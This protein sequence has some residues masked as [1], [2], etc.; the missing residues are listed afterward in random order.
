V[1]EF[2]HRPHRA[3]T[4]SSLAPLAGIRVVDFSRLFAGPICTMVL[5]DLGAE[6][7]KVEPP[8]GDEA[9]LFGPPFL[10]GEGMNYIALNRGK[11][12]VVLDLK[13]EAGAESAREL[14]GT[15]DVV[16]ENFRPG[17]TNRLQIDYASL[18]QDHPELVYCSI[19]GFGSD[20][21]YRERPALDLI[22]QGMAGVMHRQ[23]SLHGDDPR[24]VV[25]TI[26]DTYSGSLAVQ[27]VLAALYAR[28]RGAG[29]QLVE[30][31][32]FQSLL[33]A[34]AYRI[35]CAADNVE[36]SAWGDVCPYGPFRARD[37]WFNLAVVT[38][39]TWA[40]FCAAVSRPELIDDPLFRTNP[41]RVANQGELLPILAALFELRP[42][43][44]WLE[45][46]HAAGVP[47]G[48]ILRVEDLFT[49]PHVV[50]REGIV[51]MTHPTT[52]RIWTIGAPFTM[53]R[54]PLRLTTAAP[55]LGEHTDEVLSTLARAMPAREGG[56]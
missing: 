36:L 21:P 29:G 49:D 35:V 1:D 14:I 42:A 11:K 56:H 7:I 27:A 13:T 24:L 43:S 26:A 54:T 4:P 51:E 23:G 20:G 47:A 10:G 34:Q 22:L 52:G 31:D 39:K 37:E 15:A 18:R 32:L 2:A 38:D 16:V 44:H 5:A 8:S 28:E 25:I 33:F 45:T 48:P 53:A 40:A 30:V 6:V 17:V 50:A 9:R 12:S 19:T 55:L 41:D 3:R 46:M